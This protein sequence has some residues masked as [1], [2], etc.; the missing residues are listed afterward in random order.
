MSAVL[1]ITRGHRGTV[2]IISEPGNGS[3]F[4][5]FLPAVGMT[6]KSADI[7]DHGKN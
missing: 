6:G 5:I 2:K 3:L 7:A 4:R 1:G